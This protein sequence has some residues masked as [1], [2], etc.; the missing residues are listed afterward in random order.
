MG[1]Y[2]MHVWGGILR[3]MMIVLE[4]YFILIGA[5]LTKAALLMVSKNVVQS[6]LLCVSAKAAFTNAEYVFSINLYRE[7]TL[8]HA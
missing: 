7:R 8:L 5:D 1:S 3:I 2:M 4:R 6:I